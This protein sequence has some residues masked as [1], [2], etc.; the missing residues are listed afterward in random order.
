MSNHKISAIW[1]QIAD[2]EY[3]ARKTKDVIRK[4][5]LLRMSTDLRRTLPTSD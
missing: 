1:A 5:F 4:H 2:L 3:R